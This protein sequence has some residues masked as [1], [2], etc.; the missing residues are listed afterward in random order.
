MSE[1]SS[2]SFGVAARNAVLKVLAFW[3]LLVAAYLALGRQLFPYV[4]RLKPEVE[5]WL[6]DQLGTTVEIGQLRGEWNRFNPVLYLYDV[7]LGDRLSIESMTLA[8]GIYESISRGGLSFIRFEINDFRAEVVQ[9][10]T[11]WQITGLAARQ[12]DSVSLD[13]AAILALIR[14]QQEVS[15]SQV[16]FDVKPLDLPQFSLQMDDGRLTSY[17]EDNGLVANALLRAGNLEVPIELQVET[18]DNVVAENRVYFRH[19]GI[20]LSPWLTDVTPM[21]TNANISGEYWIQLQG[22]QW[23]QATGRLRLN[24]MSIEG[25][26]HEIQIQDGHAELFLTQAEKGFDSVID[27]MGYQLNGQV[28]GPTQAS[29]QYSDEHLTLKWD[30]L[31]AQWVTNVLALDDSRGFWLGLSPSGTVEQGLLNWDRNTAENLTLSADIVDLALQP[32]ESIPGLSNLDGRLYMKGNRGQIVAQGSDSRFV[33]P[34]VLAD[35][36]NAQINQTTLNWLMQAG[37]GTFASGRA[38]LV[39]EPR[40]AS[41]SEQ[42]LPVQVYWRSDGASREAKARGRESSL[43]LQLD[44][45]QAD[46]Y[47]TKVLASSQPV[48]SEVSALIRRRLQAGSFQDLQLNYLNS[49]DAQSNTHPQVFISADFHDVETEFLDDWQAAQSLDGELYLDNQHLLLNA[50]TG[51][52][53]DFELSD[54]R[55]ELPYQQNRIDLEL[56]AQSSVGNTMQFLQTGPLRKLYGDQIDQWHGKGDVAV[57]LSLSVPLNDPATFDVQVAA[58]VDAVEFVMDDFDLHFT[59]AKGITGYNRERGLY[60]DELTLKHEGQPQTVQVRTVMD[61]IRPSYTIDVQGKTSAAY[62]GKRYDDVYLAQY[63]E[64][65]EHHTTIRT[66]PQFV[67]IASSADLINIPLTLPEPLNKPVGESLPLQLTINLDERNW[68]TIRTRIGEHLQSYI[69][70][71]QNKEI[72]RG[73]VAYNSELNVRDDKGLYFDIN[74]AQSNGDDWWRAITD[75]RQLYQEAGGNGTGL[76]PLIRAIHIEAERVE[77]LSQPW[78]QADITILR[79][80]NGWLASF[81]AEEGQGRVLIPHDD[82]PI[83]ADLQW[84]SITSGEDEIPFEKQIDPLADYQPSAVPDMQVQINKLIWNQRDFGNWRAVLHSH[85]DRLDVTDIT[86]EMT[87]AELTGTLE[88]R[89]GDGVPMTTF[90]GSVSIGNILD[91]LNTWQYA[92]VLTSRGGRIDFDGGW[93]GSPAFFDFKRLTGTMQI[94]LN[95]GAIKAVEEYNGVKLI[96]LLNFTRVLRRVALDFSDLLESG[97]TY[98]TISGELLFDRGFARVGEKLLIDGSATKFRFSGDADLLSNSL[99]ADM[100]LVVPLSSTFPLVALLAG[101]SPQAAAAIYVTERVFNNELE[102]ISSA[103]MHVTGSFEDPQ[104]RFY[105]VFDN[106][107]G[108]GDDLSSVTG[109]LLEVVPEGVKTP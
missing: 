84:I 79:N 43:E 82:E 25:D 100:V 62:W 86:G 29:M 8:P 50:A 37:E 41:V 90:I 40:I 56:D 107:V 53:A 93:R 104:I 88:W 70:M 32:Y 102:R 106:G 23:K 17:G 19:G 46:L 57:D 13:L 96:G 64:L 69:E 47:W 74:L 92:P 95:K 94:A 89:I 14:R 58:R 63:D 101:V 77:Y 38:S 7:N 61:G 87:G 65:V 31:P 20:D 30:T 28:Y 11:G 48:G 83:F 33:L 42:D 45:A 2:L 6:S 67:Q 80:E 12:S 54:I 44:I 26:D 22:A 59:D 4:E 36:Y 71:N 55:F 9:T 99:D 91:V 105:R 51:Q 15:F 24:S 73:T 3:V 108:D 98:D 39:L 16:I 52:Y 10:E 5:I 34:N 60:I 66:A 85:D 97:I 18:T 81:M 78:T 76:A 68:T 72:Q 21:L 27:L 35:E 49:F 1:E 109:R 103:R 75:L